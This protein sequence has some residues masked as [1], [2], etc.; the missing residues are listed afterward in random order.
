MGRRAVLATTAGAAGLVAAGCSGGDEPGL[1]PA[2]GGGRQDG[3]DNPLPRQ[4]YLALR[5]LTL[6]DPD[7]ARGALAHLGAV[8]GTLP[9]DPTRT[10]TVGVGPD[11]VRAARGTDFPGAA[12]LP[13][14]AS[15]AIE[16]DARGG[17]LLIQV[18][19]DRRPELTAAIGTLELAL[20]DRAE[21]FWGIDGHR[22]EVDGVGARNVLGFYDGL[23]VPTSRADLD[24]DVWLGGQDRIENATIAVVR[25]IRLDHRRF[26]LL[27]VAEQQDVIGRFKK[28]GAPLSGGGIDADVNLQAKS[29]AGVF[30]IPNDAHVR[31]AHPLFSGAGRLMLRRGYSYRNGPDDQGLAFICFQRDLTVFVRT[32]QSMDGGDRLLDFATTTGTGTFLILPGWGGD[33]PLGEVLFA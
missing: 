4:R 26:A 13:V 29:D 31:R 20:T 28:S 5:V 27:P 32:Q 25:R 19:A 11:V 1:Q 9:A 24:A 12:D 2:D 6:T 7:D 10:V 18:C 15:D 16:D 17:D 8:I 30:D 33:T 22:G 3:V 14:F 23:A 21:A